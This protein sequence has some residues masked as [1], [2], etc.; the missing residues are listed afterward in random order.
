MVGPDSSKTTMNKALIDTDIL[1]FFLR[2]RHE[3]TVRVERYLAQHG[4]LSIGIITYY[5]VLSG[6]RYRDSRRRIDAFRSLVEANILLPL[7]RASCDRAASVYADLRRSGQSLTGVDLLIAGIAL[8]HGL[9]LVTG[10]LKHFARVPGLLVED[11]STGD[12][13]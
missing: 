9:S 10:N 3:V 6:L 12:S 4:Y 1:S 2:G 11:W 5:E 13:S 8:E 7:T